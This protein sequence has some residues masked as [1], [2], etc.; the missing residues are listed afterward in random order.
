[1]QEL[2]L[3]VVSVEPCLS[4][5]YGEVEVEVLIVAVDIELFLQKPK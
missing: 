2:H 5:R 3:I 1:M 4:I